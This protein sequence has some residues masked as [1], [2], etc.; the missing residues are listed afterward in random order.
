MLPVESGFALLRLPN[1]RIAQETTASS[2]MLFSWMRDFI[3]FS[4]IHSL[5]PLPLKMAKLKS[6]PM[7]T[8]E[9]YR[10]KRCL[11][12]TLQS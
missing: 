7:M 9:P 4:G 12:F 1:T 6:T 10:S 11:K 8:P 5:H 3:R 2:S